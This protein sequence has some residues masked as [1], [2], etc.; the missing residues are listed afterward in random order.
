V[1][2]LKK[3]NRDPRD[4]YPKPVLQQG[5]LAF[6]DL[7]EGMK[8][9]GKVKNVVDFGA[10]VDIGIKESALIHV[11]ELS[12]QF[13]KDPMDVLKVGDVKEFRII[14][15]GVA[16]KR[17]GLSLKSERRPDSAGSGGQRH[18]GGQDGPRRVVVARKPEGQ[19]SASGTRGP[20]PGTRAEPQRGQ[21][22]QYGG[23]GDRGGRGGSSGGGQSS[24]PAA[25]RDDDGTSYNPFADLL[26]NRK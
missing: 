11:S 18:D 8:V 14:S 7:K 6:E 3:P 22:S 20:A 15:L 13:V 5:V 12:D 21:S 2:E 10:F 9:T 17:I 25:D 24:R 23:S 26:K 16:R 1:S 19:S 4:D